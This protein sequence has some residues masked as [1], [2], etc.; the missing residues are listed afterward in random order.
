MS[1]EADEH[2]AGRRAP[3]AWPLWLW[4]LVCAGSG[5]LVYLSFPPADLGPL[6]FVAFVPLM[7]AL[8]R[9]RSYPAAALGG[10][11]AGAAACLPAFAWVM[12]V[13]VAGWIVL[14]LYV[15]LY[16]LVAAVAFRYMQRR[17]GAGWPALAAITWVALELCRAH[18]GPGFPWLF[19]GYTQYRFGGLLQAAAFGGVYAVS[20]VVMLVNA[21]VAGMF[22]GRVPLRGRL[23]MLGLGAAVL[24]G[25][26]V[27]GRAVR[28]RL[29]LGQ[30]PVVG[31]V[32]QNIPRLVPEIFGTQKTIEQVYAE[33]GEEL[34]KAAALTESLEGSGARLVLWPETTVQ[35]PLNIAPYLFSEPRDQDLAART[36][37]ELR[38]L[39]RLLDA[40]LLVGAPSYLARSAGYVKE[41]LYG[42]NVTNFANSAVYLSPA[43]RFIDRYDKIRL[44]PFG[45][46]V[47][48]REWLPFLQRLTPMGR[49][50]TPGTDRVIFELPRR[51]GGRPVRFAALICYEDVFPELTAEF[52][53][54]GADFLVNLTDE[55]WY[56]VRGELLQ[57]LAMAVFRA[58]ETRTTVVR[59]A[60]TGVSCFIGPSGEVYARL[61]PLR[62]GS[63]TARLRLCDAVTPYV[64]YGDAFGIACLML[65]IALPALLSVARGRPAADVSAGC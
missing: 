8:R 29:V 18:L 61:E 47:P 40:Y 53:R 3:G 31:L 65:A 28:E 37:V 63:L 36:L 46:Y 32:Q 60:N 35:V 10:F 22:A 57:H 2:T 27:G 23:V 14:A 16:W 15:A 48:L 13:T 50:L 51:D 26:A 25:M 59:A 11:L 43:G 41:P 54:K 20:F 58:V 9:T 33:M 49:E 45:E 21:A 52:R 30:G 38:R 64:R 6:A 39:G 17:F 19:L 62:E 55:G 24:V 42:T 1:H 34:A 4:A 5:L 7:V 12:S 56:V 44:V